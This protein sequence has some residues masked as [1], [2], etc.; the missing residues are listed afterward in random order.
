M[1]DLMRRIVLVLLV[2]VAAL[3]G[4]AVA[5]DDGDDSPD[6][7]RMRQQIETRF[8]AQVQ[9]ML[10]LTDQQA[11]QLRATLG[12]SA[13]KR[14]AMEREERAIKR[15]LQAQLR[16]GIAANSDSV[17]RLVDRLLDLKVQYVKSFVD[18]DK[19]MAKYLTPVQ[20]A[21]FRSC[22][23]DS[24]R[25]SRRSANSDSSSA[26]RRGPGRARR[27]NALALLLAPSP[28]PAHLPAAAP[29]WRN[30]RRSGLKIRRGQPRASSTLASGTFV[31]ND[32]ARPGSGLGAQEFSDC[33]R[34]GNKLRASF[35]TPSRRSPSLTIA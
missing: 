20:R 8:G 34:T 29:E 4:R 22:G 35:A 27:R 3:S 26:C 23:S 28:L 17:G 15:A 14:R 25:G 24:W 6:A 11:T 13:P 9:E 33:A 10:G 18:E 16:P 5:Q 30:G 21:Q 1:G 2:A 12:T 31:R 32:L 19:E 7:V